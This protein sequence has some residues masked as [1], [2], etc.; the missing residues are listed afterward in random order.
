M[1]PQADPVHPQPLPT[2]QAHRGRGAGC[3][4]SQG[5][6]VGHK[7]GALSSSP[8]CLFGA[9][10]LGSRSRSAQQSCAPTPSHWSPLPILLIKP[11]CVQGTPRKWLPVVMTT[12]R[13][14]SAWPTWGPPR[15]MGSQHR[16]SPQ[17]GMALDWGLGGSRAS[18]GAALLHSPHDSVSS[19]PLKSGLGPKVQAATCPP[20]STLLS[21]PGRWGRLRLGLGCDP[22]HRKEGDSLV[23]LLPGMRHLVPGGPVSTPI[24][25]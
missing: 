20:P 13:S 19:L 22:L 6:H 1:G 17:A 15:D 18:L 16:A 3:E 11:V 23:S 12:Q 25:F 5:L 7:Q 9:L 14:P 4:R 10:G 21:Y 2:F 24:T 8:S